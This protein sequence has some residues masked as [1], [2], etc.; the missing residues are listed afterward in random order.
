MIRGTTA[1]FKFRL[2]YPADELAWVTIKFWQLNNLHVGL[3]IIKQLS[4]CERT[5]DS[6]EICVSLTPAETKR[7]SDKYKARVQL[8]GRHRPT[9]TAFG[10]PIQFIAVEPM[11][12][13]VIEDDP[14]IPSPDNNGWIIFDGGSILKVDDDVIEDDPIIPEPDENGCVIFDGGSISDA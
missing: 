14:A 7:F 6:H 4:H 12:D 9:G 13:D 5:N 11:D 3:P 10:T 2:P 1:Q 8:R